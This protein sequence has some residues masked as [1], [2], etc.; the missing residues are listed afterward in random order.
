[1]RITLNSDS[2]FLCLGKLE[3]KEMLNE[4]FNQED[5]TILN[6]TIKKIVHFFTN[7]DFCFYPCDTAMTDGCNIYLNPKSHVL[8]GMS[9]AQKRDFCIYW[10][11]HEISHVL[12][13][14]HAELERRLRTVRFP[15]TFRL[16]QNILED[17]YIETRYLRDHY[18]FTSEMRKSRNLAMQITKNTYAEMK[19]AGAD[20]STIVGELILQYGRFGV[21]HISEEE[22]KEFGVLKATFD[23]LLAIV[24]EIMVTDDSYARVTWICKAY[25][26]FLDFVSKNEEQKNKGQGQSSESKQNEGGDG[27]NSDGSNGSDGNAQNSQSNDSKEK[28]PNDSADSPKESNKEANEGNNSNKEGSKDD[29]SDGSSNDGKSNDDSSSKDGQGSQNDSQS[30]SQEKS[31]NGS[32]GN[33]ENSDKNDGSDG[34]AQNSQNGGQSSSQDPSDGSSNQSNSDSGEAGGSGRSDGSLSDSE[35]GSSSSSKNR[36]A[37]GNATNGESNPSESQN[38]SSEV[39]EEQMR[40]A[41]EEIQKNFGRDLKGV[42]SEDA[43]DPYASANRDNSN[44][45]SKDGGKGEKDEQK[46]IETAEKEKNKLPPYQRTSNYPLTE[47]QEEEI[48]KRVNILTRGLKKEIRDITDE[49]VGGLSAGRRLDNR[50]L[51]RQDGKVL[52][53]HLEPDDTTMKVGLL[54]DVSGSMGDMYQEREIALSIYRTCKELNI[55]FEGVAFNGSL[56]SFYSEND[57]RNLRGGGGTEDADA[58]NFLSQKMEKDKS[59]DKKVIIVISDGEGGGTI[60]KSSIKTIACGVNGC[61]IEPRW[62][63]SGASCLITDESRF[64]HLLCKEIVSIYRQK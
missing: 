62:K 26:I 61:N 1:M 4:N 64:A 9:K 47:A 38:D 28:S 5:L 41:M 13:T 18:M 55:S 14:P 27:E 50:H 46:A 56:F 16:F 52:A 63:P 7:A 30:S 54:V 39:T 58:Y 60:R 45:S 19:K 53:R 6:S 37:S 11:L 49:Y 43:Q 42:S 20:L 29:S 22:K 51:Y 32:D 48:K 33:G 57:I 3:E 34:N 59:T 40:K 8:D 24:D 25:D 17:G 44:Q 21:L 35:N 36:T 15:D 23:K 2:H 10:A 12:Y 31:S